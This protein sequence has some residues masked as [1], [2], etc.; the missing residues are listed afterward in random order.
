MVRSLDVLDETVASAADP[1]AFAPRLTGPDLRRRPA[2]PVSRS[3]LRHA[4]TVAEALF[5]TEAGAP[6]AE[7]LDWLERELADFL[8]R[9]GLFSVLVLRF[10]LFA[11]FFLAPVTIGRFRSL[12]ALELPERCRALDRFDHSVLSPALLACKAILCILYFE[13]PDTIREIGLDMGCLRS[14]S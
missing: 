4:R 9:T 3:L 7:R 14:A 12:S 11:V 13:H 5:S 1:A 8:G 2:L 6:P 10:S